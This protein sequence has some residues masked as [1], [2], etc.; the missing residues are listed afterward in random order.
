MHAL[1][2]QRSLYSVKL[3]ADRWEIDFLGPK[4]ASEQR[5]TGLS[6]EGNSAGVSYAC[7]LFYIELRRLRIR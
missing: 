4:K 5:L 6:P 1:P 7:T 3:R 2:E